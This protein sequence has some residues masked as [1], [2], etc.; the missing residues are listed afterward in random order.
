MTYNRTIPYNDLPD[1]PPTFDGET[2]ELIISHAVKAARSLAELKG[3]CETLPQESLYNL[4]INT[5]VL[6]ESK[7]SSAIENIVT[8]QDEL[9]QAVA[10]EAVTTSATKEVLGY[11]T[12]LYAGLEHMKQLNN[13]ISTNLMV[14]VVQKITQNTS[15]IRRTPGTALK[16]AITGDVVYTPPCCE[17]VLREKLKQ[18]EQFINEPDFCTLDPIIKLALI[19]YQFES[20]HPFGDGNGRTGR[21]LN[22]LYLVHQNLL[23]H[24]VLYLSSYIIDNKQDYYRL[25]REVTEKQNWRDWVMFITTAVNETSI[26]TIQKI[27]GILQLKKEMEEE[28]MKVL[29]K[30]NKRHELYNLMFTIPYI[31]IELVAKKGIAHRQTAAV[32]LQELESKGILKPVKMGK[33]TYYVNHRLLDLI[34]QR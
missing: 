3:L 29:E 22:S 11:R 9:Y 23:S 1:L 24:P 18:L 8:T 5:I 26:L 33:T 27:R 28:T 4:F 10:D 12:A 14:N 19:H 13:I 6:Q 16:N 34:T 2:R 25:L 20:I 31:R 21:I 15:G 30:F 7:D 17:D 32:Y